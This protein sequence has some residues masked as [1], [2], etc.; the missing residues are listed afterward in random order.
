MMEQRVEIMVMNVTMKV[1]APN[2]FI[3]IFHSN[4][5]HIFVRVT[6]KH[7]ISKIKKSY[8]VICYKQPLL[9]NK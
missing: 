6:Q 5:L 4:A 2:K 8:V 9:L 1:S 3:S 7:I